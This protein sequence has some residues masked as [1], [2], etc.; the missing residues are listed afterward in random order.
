[1]WVN[2]CVLKVY[3][4]KHFDG[5][6]KCQ[7]VA[8]CSNRSHSFI[9]IRI[10]PHPLNTLHTSY[11]CMISYVAL[12]ELQICVMI[13]S[14][15][16]WIMVFLPLQRKFLSTG[17]RQRC[18]CSEAGNVCFSLPRSTWVPCKEEKEVL[19]S[20]TLFLI[21]CPPPPSYSSGAPLLERGAGNLQFP[22]RSNPLNGL[23]SEYPHCM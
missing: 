22:H 15:R 18:I 7:C 5:D 6:G 17:E 10:T 8:L 4:R 23:T 20:S 3:K 14:T 1:M 19:L 2:I 13:L 12:E 21:L 16:N 9:H 11:I